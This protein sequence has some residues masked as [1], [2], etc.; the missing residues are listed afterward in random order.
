MSAQSPPLPLEVWERSLWS[1]N[2]SSKV[3]GR[4][5]DDDDYEFMLAPLD[6]P[7]LSL[8][9]STGCGSAERRYFDR[10]TLI[11]L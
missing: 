2:S 1:A 7:V 4:E 8:P 9:E 10:N 6:Q 11:M 3:C 5:D